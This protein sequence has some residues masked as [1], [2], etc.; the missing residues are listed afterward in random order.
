MYRLYNIR[1]CTI[2]V[3][4]TELYKNLCMYNLQFYTMNVKFTRLYLQ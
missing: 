1:D 4:Y 2:Y 3:K